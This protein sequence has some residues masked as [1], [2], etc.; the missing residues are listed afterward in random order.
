M[1]TCRTCAYLDVQPRAD[2]KIVP[3][4]GGAY[5]CTAPIP[6]M[7]VFPRSVTMRYEFKWPP[8]QSWMWPD[9]GEG[10]PTYTKRVKAAA[11][12]KAEGA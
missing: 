2:G 5:P 12:A 4:K 1:S 11:I 10:C 7:P 3:R 9:A 8:K 6:A